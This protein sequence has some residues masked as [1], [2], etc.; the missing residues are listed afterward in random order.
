MGDFRAFRCA[1][2]IVV[3]G[4]DPYA[5]APLYACEAA[6]ESAGL[7][8]ARDGVALPA[9]LPGYD[10][11]FFALFAI[12]PLPVAALLWVALSF[13]AALAALRALVRCGVGDMAT[14][15]A[16][17]ALGFGIVALPFGE[18]APFALAGACCCADALRRGAWS[19]A[20]AWACI[21][22]IE[23]HVGLPLMLVTIGL[24]RTR[25]RAAVAIVVLAALHALAVR[26]EGLDYFTHVLPQ[27]AL[28]EL[29]RASQYGLAW[30]LQALGAAPGIALGIGTV[31]YA[32]AI[33]IGISLGALIAQRRGMPAALALVP[34]ACALLGGAFIHLSQM[35]L[36]LPAIALLLPLPGRA[37][38]PLRAGLPLVAIPWSALVSTPAS[39]VAIAFACG[40]IARTSLR[41]S[42]RAALFVALGATLYGASIVAA[43]AHAISGAPAT[44]L[45]ALDPTLAQASWGAW[46][47]AHDSAASA[48]I[49]LAK[50]PTW[51]GLALALAGFAL[52]AREQRVARGNGDDAPAPTLA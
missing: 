14:V 9:P 25:L 21:A 52:L 22:M 18:L 3:R 29:P 50:V 35:M 16:P 28:A 51:A 11:A 30:I 43:A 26:G 2:S 33:G 47:R 7:Y 37:S 19:A 39:I 12:V 49:W 38:A 13:A 1:G 4:G 24:E 5:A 40:V 8:T 32:L 10:L 45:P 36:A 27:H 17:F 42:T 6:P 46:I 48:A 23:P 41:L 15:I 31:S 20:V 34:C 44:A